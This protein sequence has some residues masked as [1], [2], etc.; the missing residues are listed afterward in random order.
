MPTKRHS[1]REKPEIV[2][3]VDHDVG[4][5]RRRTQ[6]QA[7]TPIIST[8]GSQYKTPTQTAAAEKETQ[9]LVVMEMGA[10]HCQ[11]MYRE[12]GKEWTSV[13]W[14][15][16]GE[17]VNRGRLHVMPTV[18]AYSRGPDNKEIRPFYGQEAIDQHHYHRQVDTFHHLKLAFV[19]V[20]PTPAV[21]T[22]LDEQDKRAKA[23]GTNIIQVAIAF[24]EHALHNLS[25]VYRET[26]VLY[27][28]IS[29]SW[30]NKASQRLL[31]R[32][33]TIL[34]N[35]EIHAIDEC[36]SSALGVC[37]GQSL[38]GMTRHCAF[39][40]A[41]CG[42]STM[43]LSRLWPSTKKH[44]HRIRDNETFSLGAGNIN[45]AAEAEVRE[46][47]RLQGLD[48]ESGILGMS[49]VID[50]CMK[51]NMNYTPLPPRG[52]DE[53]EWHRVTTAAKKANDELDKRRVDRIQHMLDKNRAQSSD[54]QVQVILTGNASKSKTF[55]E[56]LSA[57][58]AKKYPEAKICHPSPGERYLVRS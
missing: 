18:A 7:G 30:S 35:V 40:A 38:N 47:N 55:L 2:A 33:Q 49:L 11:L 25:G 51:P 24:F 14:P 15:E 53:H 19:K 36:L 43:N 6:S 56:R 50:K 44:H 46:I 54:Q 31:R 28:N 23:Y 41:D 21:Q 4:N 27:F 29:D 48:L 39:I 20:A 5:K 22:T 42:H 17:G 57:V 10:S 52:F 8:Q 34:P 9:T 3:A 37:H 45:A 58:V 1:R 13:T 32:F 12:P 26:A 16:E